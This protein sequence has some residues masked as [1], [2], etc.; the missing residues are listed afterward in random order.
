MAE[1]DQPSSIQ[2]GMP[3]DPEEE[4]PALPADAE[5][6]KA[7]AALSSLDAHNNTEDGAPRTQADTEAL[8]KAMSQLAVAGEEKAGAKD[9][10]KEAEVKKKVKVEAG[11]ITLLVSLRL[12]ELEGLKVRS[13]KQH[14]LMG[15][16]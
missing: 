3:I 16:G 2:E 15:I 7:A 13:Q 1:P 8:G 10:K 11:D 14:L 4:T 9:P 6:R 5:G 12:L